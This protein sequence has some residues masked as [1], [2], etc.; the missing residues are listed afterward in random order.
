MVNLESETLPAVLPNVGEH[1]V[2]AP[3]IGLA[4]YILIPLRLLQNR[5]NKDGRI[6]GARGGTGSPF[7]IAQTPGKGEG[8]G[9]QLCI[10]E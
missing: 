1:V 5:G 7:H 10:Q 3:D 8:W 6:S 9:V 4:S 2:D